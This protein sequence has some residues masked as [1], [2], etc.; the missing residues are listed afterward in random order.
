[1]PRATVCPDLSQYQ[2]LASGQLPGPEE[3]D[4]LAHLENC[5]GCARKIAALP[6]E[7]ALVVKLRQAETRIDDPS[8]KNF[9]EGVERSFPEK[10]LRLA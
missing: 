4:L 7:D 3:E 5:D 2:R 8:G 6:E 9:P 10:G 1:M